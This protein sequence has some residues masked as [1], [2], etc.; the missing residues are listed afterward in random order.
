MRRP[1]ILAACLSTAASL[2]SGALAVTLAAP[3]AQPIVPAPNQCTIAPRDVAFFAQFVG[4]PAA[5]PVAEATP[6]AA[7]FRMPDGE[8]A[9]RAIRIAV[10]DTIRQ[11]AACF[12][13]GNYLALASL[14]T[15]DYFRRT[16]ES[17]GP[18]TEEDLAFL[19][20]TPEPLPAGGQAAILAILDVRVLP[21]G[22]A[23]VLIDVF[24]PIEEPPGPARV[25]IILVEQD[26][27][28]L[29]DDLIELGSI[30]EGQVGTPSA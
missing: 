2:L 16:A 8:A 6:D 22:R 12:N 7:S 29:I 23:A 9:D 11:R 1:A 3:N 21:D 13:A 24:D 10:L 25:L 19:A 15:D 20:S 18:L 5:S 4:T 26:G 27:R 17:E 30:D 14:Y 28:W